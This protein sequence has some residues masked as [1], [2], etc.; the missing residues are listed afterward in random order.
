MKEA[1]NILAK[2]FLTPRQFLALE[3]QS[4]EEAR[5]MSAILRDTWWQS[6]D[7]KP[8]THFP[9]RP[10]LGQFRAKFPSGRSARTRVRMNN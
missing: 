4:E 10:N 1:H 7:V 2:T 5:S 9:S 3:K 6:K 8:A